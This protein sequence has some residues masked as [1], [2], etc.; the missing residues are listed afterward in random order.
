MRDGS[1]IDSIL[2]QLD[3]EISGTSKHVP[4]PTHGGYHAGYGRSDESFDM[5][6]GQPFFLLPSSI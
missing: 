3:A 1:H 6:G 2:E 4:T 5:S